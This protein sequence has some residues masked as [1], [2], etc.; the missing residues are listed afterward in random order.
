LAHFFVWH[1]QVDQEE[2]EDTK[3]VI[4]ICKSKKDKQHNSQKKKVKRTNTDQQD[5]TQKSKDQGTRTSQQTGSEFR[6]SRR[7]GRTDHL[8]QKIQLHHNGLFS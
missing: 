6:C 7:V 4:R 8:L 3:G 1:R 5:P 2:F